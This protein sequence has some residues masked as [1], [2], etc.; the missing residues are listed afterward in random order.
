MITVMP[1]HLIPRPSRYRPSLLV[2]LGLA[3]IAAAA[4]LSIARLHTLTASANVAVV[5]STDLAQ[6]SHAAV[7]QD[8]D[9]DS[10]GDEVSPSQ[11]DQYV[12]VYQAMQ[13]D[14]TL[15]V[16]QATAREHLTVAQF[17]D[18][19]GRIERDGVLRERV[20]RELL[21]SAQEKSN[22]LKL[23]PQSAPSSTEP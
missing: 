20:R 4:G 12:K 5:P 19:E 16:E 1:R 15:T 6:D 14:R 17:R 11:L 23:K 22:A 18:I 8:D 3:L 13:H 10:K 21:K 2:A 7:A 9:Q